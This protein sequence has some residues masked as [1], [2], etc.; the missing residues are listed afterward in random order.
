MFLK[1]FSCVK[2][3]Q[4]DEMTHNRNSVTHS[5]YSSIHLSL[6]RGYSLSLK[7]PVIS[8]QNVSIGL[9]RLKLQL[10]VQDQ[11]SENSG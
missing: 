3:F 8:D 7:R 9:E 11:C 10:Q 1:D 5:L 6:D 2:T 4:N